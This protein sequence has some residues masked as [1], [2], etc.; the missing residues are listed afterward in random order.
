M[1]TDTNNFILDKSIHIEGTL[2]YVYTYIYTCITYKHIIHDNNIVCILE[3]DADMSR[4]IGYH[5]LPGQ[6]RTITL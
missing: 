3:A 4:H 6:N 1:P 2:L 5:R